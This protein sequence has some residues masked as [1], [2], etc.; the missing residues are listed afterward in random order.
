MTNEFFQIVRLIVVGGIS[1]GAAMLIEP[2]LYQLLLRL[3]KGKQIRTE[4]APIF[5]SLHMKKAGTPTMGGVMIWSVVVALTFIFFLLS[6]IFD[7]FWSW[8]NFWSRRQTFLPLAAFLLAA[9]TGLLDD[10]LGVF[11]IGARGGGLR[12][13]EKIIV[14]VVIATLGAWWFYTKLGFDTLH[15]PFWGDV[16]LGWWY[17]PFFVLVVAATAFSLNE[18]DGLDGLAGGIS[19]PALGALGVVSFV[20]GRYDLAAFVASIIG[21]LLAFLWYNIYPAKFF[22]G[23]TGAMS[24]GISIGVLAMLTNTAL[25]LPFF[26]FMLV[27]ESLSVII[28]KAYRLLFGKKLFLS[29]PIHHHFEAR[30]WHETRITMRFWIV[31]GVAA[32]LGLVVFFLDRLLSG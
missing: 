15:I 13:R 7:G 2:L 11:G 18:A 3:G 30:G 27:V 25:L 32:S 23:D 20:Q 1:F 9:L 10:L 28:Q 5:A 6:K 14:Y 19:L 29:T 24:L 26:G 4:G 16:S 22:M 12:V 8:L 31:S 21:A 17:V